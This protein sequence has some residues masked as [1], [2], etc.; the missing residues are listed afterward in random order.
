MKATPSGRSWTERVLRMK[1]G[2]LSLTSAR[3]RVDAGVMQMSR[4]PSSDSGRRTWRAG[5]GY[6]VGTMGGCMQVV[7]EGRPRN[8]EAAE[9]ESQVDQ[10]R[11]IQGRGAVDVLAGPGQR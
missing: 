10:R 2:G 9:Q 11:S 6:R 8:S 4:D 1:G 5:A 7:E 3:C